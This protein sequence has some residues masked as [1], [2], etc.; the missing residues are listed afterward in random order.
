M[1]ILLVEDD[2]LQASGI[3]RFLEE[4]F[5]ATVQLITNEHG[6]RTQI[7]AIKTAPPD[8][9]VLDPLLHW[10]DPSPDPDM[11]EPPDEVQE[12][13]YFQAGFRCLRMFLDSNGDAM[14]PAIVYSTLPEERLAWASGRKGVEIAEKHSS[15][16][17]LGK[18]IRALLM[19]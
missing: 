2:H 11:P 16:D 13:G 7:E 19:P 18:A 6:F 17:S 8:L 9:I 12:G 15:F 10:A 3:K 4:T 14:I 1:N 5:Q